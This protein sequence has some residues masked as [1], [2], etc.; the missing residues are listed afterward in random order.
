MNL[1]DPND[2]RARLDDDLPA[3]GSERDRER[4]R[5]G[6]PVLWLVLGAIAVLAFVLLLSVSGGNFVLH[7]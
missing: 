6:K 3:G 4:A 7:R 1:E 2:R 5:S